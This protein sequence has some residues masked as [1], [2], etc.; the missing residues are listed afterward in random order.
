LLPYIDWTFFFA[1]WELK[2]RFPGILR[3]PEYGPA[4]RE[5]YEHAQTVLARIVSGKLITPRGVYGFWPA[6]TDGDDIVVFLDDARKT[7]VARFP[8]LRQQEPI[9]DDK[10]NRSLADLVSPRESRAPA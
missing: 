9:A 1:A 10:P 8:M 7:E 5:L 2:G 6:N 3:H 4:A